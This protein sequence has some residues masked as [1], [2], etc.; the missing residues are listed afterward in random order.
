MITNGAVTLYHAQTDSVSRQ[1][2]FRR[3]VFPACSIY[4]TVSVE[5]RHSQNGPWRERKTIIRIPM[6]GEISL[7]VGDRIVLNNCEQEI[8]PRESLMVCGFSDHRRGSRA[9]WHWKVICR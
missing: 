5:K 4:Q 9:V 7:A 6:T 3:E 2:V 8:P 1:E